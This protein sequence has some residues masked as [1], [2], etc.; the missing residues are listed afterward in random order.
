MEHAKKMVLVEPRQI[1]KYKETMLD[2]TLSKLDGEIYN[3]LHRDIADDEKAK[4]YSNTL[5]RYL[6]LDKPIQ[7][8][9][10]T[11][12]DI[13][14]SGVQTTNTQNDSPN[15]LETQVLQTVPKKW[16]AQ[17]SRLLGHMNANP[18]ITWSD[19]GEL[20]LKDTIIPKTH[21][22]DLI[23]DLLRKRISTANPT[24]WT[25]L[26][27]VLKEDNI[28]RELIGNEDRWKYITGEQQAS[29]AVTPKSSGKRKKR[30]QV[31]LKKR[32]NWE[33]YN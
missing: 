10:F 24:G 8:K 11:L 1:E 14:S 31:Q 21:A 9:T 17:A 26:A 5:S 23:N 29:P 3:L 12:T 13:L 19:K 4:L 15:P 6:S 32:F 33:A 27:D 20:I 22:V 2:K 28:P 30:Q 7:S 25:Q 18:D 16:K